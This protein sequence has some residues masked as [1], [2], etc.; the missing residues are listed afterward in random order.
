MMEKSFRENYQAAL[1][2]MKNLTDRQRNILNAALDL[3]AENGYESTS[4][5]QI[6]KKA[7]VAVGSVYH[8]FPNKEELLMAVMTPM[9]EEVFQ[10]SA[11]QFIDQTLG[12][13][14]KDFSEFIHS[15]VSDRF[16]FIDENFKII[17]VAFV[18]L[19]TKPTLRNQ[20]KEILSKQLF[21]SAFPVLDHFK[22]SG[23]I[24]NW[25]N[26]QI[27]EVIFAPFAVHFGKLLFEIA[28]DGTADEEREISIACQNIERVL[29]K[30]QHPAK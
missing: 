29:I 8:V 1:N 20:V 11:D 17:K 19:L 6:A 15:L 13:Q 22:E 7:G 18:E 23:D 21:Q 28:P 4:T 10:A 9:F 26:E 2:K 14:Y 16:R 12:K 25:N 27:M 24:E 3:F 5:S 30:K